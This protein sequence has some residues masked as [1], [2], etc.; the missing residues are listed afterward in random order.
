MTLEKCPSPVGELGS[1][2]FTRNVSGA[3]VIAGDK[4]KTIEG[5]AFN[6]TSV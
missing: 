3:R 5:H 2:L 1:M 4:D 6:R